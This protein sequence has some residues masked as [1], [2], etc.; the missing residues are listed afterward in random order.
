MIDLI[1]EYGADAGRGAIRQAYRY[2][3]VTIKNMR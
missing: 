3:L 2:V 1:T